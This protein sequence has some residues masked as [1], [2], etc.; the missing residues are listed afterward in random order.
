MAEYGPSATQLS[1]P[2]GA[3]AQVI[4]PVQQTFVPRDIASGIGMVADVFSKYSEAS[5]KEE[6]EKRKQDVLG[7]YIRSETVI[8]DAVAQGLDAGQAAARSRANGNKFL[9]SYPEY[10]KDFESA[11]N[12]LK[13]ITEAGEVEDEVKE[14]KRLF[15]AQI[16]NAQQAGYT[17]DPSMPAE[18][19]Q[20]QIDSHQTEVRAQ[21]ELDR[22]YK[23]RSDIR[24]QNAEDRAV[25][26]RHI[27]DTSIKVLNEVAGA[28][29]Q[30]VGGFVASLA[31]DVKQGKIP[32]E[33][34]QLKLTQE[35]SVINATLQSAA[36]VNPELA[37]P[38]RT[39]FRE[40]QDLG[41]K[42]IDPKTQVENSDNQIK[43][44]INRSKLMILSDPN[45]AN[46]V[47][48][49]QLLG[50][51]AQIALAAGNQVTNQIA[52]MIK[53]PAGNGEYVPQ[54]VGNP[55]VQTGTIQFLKKSIADL[56]TVKFKD[57]TK[58]REELTNAVNQTLIQT[59]SEIGKS[60][61]AVQLKEWA[62]F[63][64]SPEYGKFSTTGGLNKQ[65]AQAAKNVFE[66]NY[67]STIIRGVQQKLETYLQGQAAFGQK[68]NVPTTIGE[69]VNAV[70]TGSGVA[71]T[72]KARP[73]LDP[74]E[75][76]D[77]AR[78]I[79]DLNTAAAAINQ[80][81]HIGTHLEGSTDYQKYW[82][83]RKYY[84]LPQMFPIKPGTIINGY[85][86]K[87]GPVDDGRSYE[88]A[89]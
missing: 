20:S 56:D 12:S 7:Q 45:S 21:A 42:L 58:A 53:T 68:Q 44:L 67:E 76:T 36:S 39:L 43:E 54:V 57:N 37:S 13:G 9:A 35:F 1:A 80:L 16:S 48:A 14:R 33:Q 86:Y 52:S 11:R 46:I 83:E 18:V 10:A 81:I 3:G 75:R 28:R 32:L 34:A 38:Y 63:F 77:Q 8:N 78:A 47:A 6:A 17:I 41:T 84:L 88:P 19:I 73:D 5:K 89:N 25:A 79:T 70:F 50:A 74:N 87:G 64:A 66:L 55:T 2:Q 69:S 71:F 15:R 51:N 4:A 59:G 82:E 23:A 22:A 26:D 62:Q 27:K 49:S 29:M 24:A 72:P 61:N 31:S 30:A 85:R 60:L 40:M 65:A